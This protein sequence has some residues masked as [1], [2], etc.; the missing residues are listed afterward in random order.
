MDINLD[1]WEVVRRHN[2]FH[3][4]SK[5]KLLRAS[6]SHFSAMNFPVL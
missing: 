6:K 5:Y 1:G 3:Q 2:I 4:T